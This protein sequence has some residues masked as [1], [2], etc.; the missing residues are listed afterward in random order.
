MEKKNKQK[1]N[2]T[3]RIVKKNY[4]VRIVT[5]AGDD[6]F[7]EFINALVQIRL[8]FTDKFVFKT[9]RQVKWNDWNGLHF[10]AIIFL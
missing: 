6:F 4:L 8:E 10:F 1:K 9:D 2:E 7:D 5:A 3:K